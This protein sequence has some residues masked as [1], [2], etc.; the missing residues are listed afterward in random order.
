[1]RNELRIWLTR[2]RRS[3]CWLIRWVDPATKKLCQK[4]T[5]ETQKKAVE[6]K[7]GEFRADN[8][9][10]EEGKKLESDEGQ[11]NYRGRV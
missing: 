8:L 9:P 6:R 2:S 1:M 11:A 5:G 10:A 7:L 4:S 3:R